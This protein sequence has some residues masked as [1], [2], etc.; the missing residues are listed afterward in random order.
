MFQSLE[1]LPTAHSQ[2]L[3]TTSEWYTTKYHDAF[4]QVILARYERHPL[5][6]GVT[7]M[8]EPTTKSGTTSSPSE[9]RHGHPSEKRNWKNHAVTSLTKTTSLELRKDG[10]A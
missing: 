1:V 8:W 6:N 7:V 9:D 3:F 10:I 4:L 2:T 5:R